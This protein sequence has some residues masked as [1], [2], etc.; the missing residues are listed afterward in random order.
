MDK[1]NLIT[2][3]CRNGD[4]ETFRWLL[5]KTKYSGMEW[6]RN[7]IFA[8]GNCNLDIIK[9]ISEHYLVYNW[10]HVVGVRDTYN[11]GIVL[12][13]INNKYVDPYVN[14]VYSVCCARYGNIMMEWFAEKY[15]GLDTN[16]NIGG[17]IYYALFYGYR[18]KNTR[19]IIKYIFDNYPDANI[20]INDCK[21]VLNCLYD[22]LFIKNL[23]E[24][25]FVWD[26]IFIAA[27]EHNV[28]V[29]SKYQLESRYF[30]GIHNGVRVYGRSLSNNTDSSM[31]QAIELYNQRHISA[32]KKSAMITK[33]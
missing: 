5:E 19:L 30:L 21:I 29:F 2:D 26:P 13:A 1:K 18:D 10:D 11:M 24:M 15:P 14:D 3:V 33:N 8:Y 17:I 27:S 6:S 12:W 25:T 4:Y 7:L 16:D 32:T 9:Y 23:V 28:Y 22:G 31:E 20:C